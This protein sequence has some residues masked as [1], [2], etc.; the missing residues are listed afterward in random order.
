[1]SRLLALLVSIFLSQH[2]AAV[3]CN[4]LTRLLTDK[5]PLTIESMLSE[6]SR[7]SEWKEYLGHYAFMYKSKSLQQGTP[8][9]PRAIVY[10]KDATMIMAFLNGPQDGRDVVELICWRENKKVFE[11]F[12]L[13]FDGSHSPR[14]K[15]E[16][17][18]PQRCLNCHGDNPRPNWEA[19]NFWSGT[20]GSVTRGGESYMKPGMLELEYYTA[21]LDGNRT[22]G[23][24]QYLPPESPDRGPTHAAN[25]YSFEP[26]AEILDALT[27][28][29]SK[30]LAQIIRK[31]PHYREFEPA[32][33][34]VKRGC[35]LEDMLPERLKNVSLT[36]AKTKEDIEA[37]Q[38]EE[39]LRRVSEFS[40]FNAGDDSSREPI[41]FLPIYYMESLVGVRYLFDRMNVPFH[42]ISYGFDSGTYDF[43]SNAFTPTSVIDSALSEV[44]NGNESKDCE[45]IKTESLRRLEGVSL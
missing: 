28:L 39:F 38:T 25:T 9:N 29:N 42:R 13:D 5:S 4:D 8:E 6:M 1:M 18:N 27:P 17:A 21:F 41:N 36:Y 14:I 32:F 35:N 43:T 12:E 15:A 33:W 20:F 2:A 3:D 7:K 11:F 24:Y 26:A 45:E 16:N 23:R 40:L 10:G 19:Y 22:K 44:T 30:R 34:A 31:A 37:T